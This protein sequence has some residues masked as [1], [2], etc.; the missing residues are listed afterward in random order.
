MENGSTPAW[1]PAAPWRRFL[2]LLALGLA[3]FWPGL[4][5]G[6]ISDD[7]VTLERSGVLAGEPL[8]LFSIPP[9]NFRTTLYLAFLFLKAIFGYHAWVF[10]LFALG[11]HA[12]NATLLASLVGRLQGDRGTGFLAGVL[13]VAYQ[14]PQEAFLWLNGMH[15]S[16]QGLFALAAVLF[17]LQGRW[18]WS[19]AAYCLALFSKES[20]AL[21][22]ALIPVTEY[23]RDDRLSWRRE[24][25]WFA[26]PTALFGLLFLALRSTNSLLVGGYYALGPGAAWVWLN[27]LHRIAFPWIYLTAALAWWNRKES[28]PGRVAGPIL[29]M[30][31]SLLPY[32]FLTYQ[33]HV[34]SRHQ[35]LACM[36]AAALLAILLRS[37]PDR[38]LAVVVTAAFVTVNAAYV[39]L[40]KDRQFERRAAPTEQLLVYLR[41]HPPQRLRLLDYPF[42]PW[43][44]KLTTRLV[45]GWSPDQILD[46]DCDDCPVLRW[47]SASDRYEER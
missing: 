1:T 38:R 14:N 42:N 18:K 23:W 5:N 21:I 4:D 41:A 3:V 43:T 34:P 19:L 12:L 16:L 39:G 32:I 40:V 7:Y 9:E 26:V 47:D 17:W 31:I 25:A 20:A 11:L 46:A 13:F 2:V 35:Y 37:L 28:R 45:P 10:Y 33:N 36:G 27:S 6:F 30:A 22:L 29:W 44:A 15:E 24:F 8:Y